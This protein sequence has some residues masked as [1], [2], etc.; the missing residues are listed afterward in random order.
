MF[1]YLLHFD[2][3]LSHAEHYAGSTGDIKARLI[4]HAT[5]NGARITE[6]TQE[7]GINWRLAALGTVAMGAAKRTERALKDSHNLPRYCPICS[8][9]C[10]KMPGTTPYPIEMLKFKTDAKGLGDQAEEQDIDVRLVTPAEGKEA[11]AFI[12]SL[13]RKDKDALGFIP[14]GGPEGIEH[15]VQRRQIAI[16]ANNGQD[17]GYT[18]FTLNPSRSR[19]SIQQTCVQDDARHLRHGTAMVQ[20]VIASRPLAEVVCK[21]RED[22]PA[23]FF[24]SAIGFEL[25]RKTNHKTSG[26]VLLNFAH[27]SALST[28]IAKQKEESND[29]V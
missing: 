20:F 3:C 18:A 21:V 13:M 10:K 28:R 11:T 24:W 17:V 4:A 16:V 12:L 8:P 5:G 19:L 6:A 23:I 25:V 1:V 9:G 14:C 29:T 15:L 26:S 2:N 7:Q 27:K 22:L